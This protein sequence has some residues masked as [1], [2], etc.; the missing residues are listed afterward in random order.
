[1]QKRQTV[2]KY[3]VAAPKGV[4]SSNGN[5]FSDDDDYDHTDQSMLQLENGNG[6]IRD[7]WQI[8]HEPEWLGESYEDGESYEARA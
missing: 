1:M 5:G 4:T 2:N 6:A 7:S 8:T 3:K